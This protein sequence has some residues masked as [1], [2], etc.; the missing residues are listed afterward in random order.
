MPPPLEARRSEGLF[1]MWSVSLRRFSNCASLALTSS[2]SDVS[3]SYSSRGGSRVLISSCLL[4]AVGSLGM[5]AEGLGDR[6]R[7]VFLLGLNLL[8]ECGEGLRIVPRLV[9][10]FHTQIVGFKHARS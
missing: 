2:N 7:L 8:E 3:S 10:V 9:H 6:S 5:R 1:S 4:D